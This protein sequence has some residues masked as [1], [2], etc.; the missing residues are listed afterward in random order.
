MSV[1]LQ[2]HLYQSVKTRC[3]KQSCPASTLYNMCR[4]WYMKVIYYGQGSIFDSLS[5]R[6]V[7]K[8]LAMYTFKL[9]LSCGHRLAPIHH[10]RGEV[11]NCT[12]ISIPQIILNLQVQ[13]RFRVL[14]KF[15]GC[16]KTS[17]SPAARSARSRC[18]GARSRL[19]QRA[20]R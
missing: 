2:C 20:S 13:K 3:F 16:S 19:V 18:M 5:F 6:H 11:I 10:C 17:R 9:H 7:Q 1:C 4:K 12:S 15:T 8:L 14:R